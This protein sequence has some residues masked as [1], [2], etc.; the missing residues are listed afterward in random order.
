M[1]DGSFLLSNVKSINFISSLGLAQTLRER[2]LLEKIQAYL[3]KLPMDNQVN[4]DIVHLLKA[5]QLTDY[6]SSVMEKSKITIWDNPPVSLNSKPSC[7]LRVVSGE[8]FIKT[9]IPYLDS[10]S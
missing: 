3:E 4:N 5:T 8:F 2:P 6:N 10:L 9:F 1:G 7:V